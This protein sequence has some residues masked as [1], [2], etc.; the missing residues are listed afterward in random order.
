MSSEP[1]FAVGIFGNWGT[2]KT[3]LMKMIEENLDKTN[4]LT[5]WFEAWRYDRD[6]HFALLPFLRQ[7]RIK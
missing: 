1:R 3:S 7:L 6:T 2:G 4:T 5:V